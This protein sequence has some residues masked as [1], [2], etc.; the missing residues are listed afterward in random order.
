MPV[1]NAEQFVAIAIQS[2]LQ[3]SYTNWE[4]II[5]D[6]GST[7][8]SR[9]IIG[10]FKD[11]RVTFV[12]HD[13]N[14]GIAQRLNEA[15]AMA[16]GIYVA[17]MDADDCM[18]PERLEKQIAFLDQHTNIDLLGSSA[19]VINEH[20]IIQG[21]RVSHNFEN[22]RSKLD[23]SVFIHP[24]I[25]GKLS[26][27]KTNKYDETMSGAEDYE[28]FI[29]TIHK[30][31]FYNSKE[32]L[33]FYREVSLPKISTYMYR[34][35]KVLSA[36][37]KNRLTFSNLW[38]YIY[39]VGRINCKRHLFYLVYLLGLSQIWIR[40]RNKPI[41]MDVYKQYDTILNQFSR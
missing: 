30:S 13:E 6:D 19:V 25:I 10:S 8:A 15:I 36:L 2:V 33:L 24:T 27:F 31:V 35:K 41:S 37:N 18:F 40:I 12:S 11:E 29:R 21:L 16:N 23:T 7:D 9:S 34:Q 20:N 5:I 3:Q 1:Y 28:L 14:L 26:W 39:L 17:R 4:L 38:K 32:P 22:N